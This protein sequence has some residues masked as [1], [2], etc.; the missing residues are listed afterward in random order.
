MTMTFS[1]STYNLLKQALR[2]D[3]GSGDRTSRLLIEPSH[4]ACAQIFSKEAGVFCGSEIVQFLFRKLDSK[5][6]I[7]FFTS[8]GKSFIKGKKLIEIRGKLRAILGAERTVLNLLG[9]LCGVATLT[10]AFVDQAE[11]LG[12]EIF[13]TRKTTPLWRELEKYAVRTGGGSNHR[14]GLYDEIFVKENH[15]RFGNLN[16]L[17][18]YPKKFVIEARDFRELIQ[19]M[20]F[21]PRVL[22]IDNASPADLKR[23]VTF[24][25]SINPRVQ[26]EASGGITLANVKAYARTGVDRISVGAITHSAMSVDLSLLVKGNNREE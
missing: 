11:P 23:A 3:L 25:R 8:D 1:K 14:H 2:E 18:K 21:Q 7:K 17:K 26:I 16:K 13:D 9:H 22:L 15:K 20:A 10:R 5:M 24:A 4:R 12:V 19:A 6:H